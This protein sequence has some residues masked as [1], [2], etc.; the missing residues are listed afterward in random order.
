MSWYK[1]ERFGRVLSLKG[2]QQLK[3]ANSLHEK[4]FNVKKNAWKHSKILYYP[5]LLKII[6]SY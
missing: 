3:N 1:K 6:F 2:I 4:K 5:N